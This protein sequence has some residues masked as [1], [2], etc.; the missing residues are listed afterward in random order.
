MT[1]WGCRRMIRPLF[2][3]REDR[4]PPRRGRSSVGRASRSQCEGQGFDSPRLHH[5]LPLWDLHGHLGNAKTFIPGIS[6]ASTKSSYALD[7]LEPGVAVMPDCFVIQPFDAGEFDKRFDDICKPALKRAG[8]DAY[9]VD[10]DPNADVL[11]DTI[12]ERISK[13]A[14]CLADITS[15]NPNVWYEL[16][17]AFAVERPVILI[18][19]ANR[20]D[21]FPFD[22]Q[23]RKVIRYRTESSSD[24]EKLGAQI[25]EK[26][27]A[28]LAKSLSIKKV[29]ETENVA[30]T[31]GL[32]HHEVLVLAILA[33]DAIIPESTTHINSLKHDAEKAGLTSV[34]F[35]LALRRLRKR[36]FAKTT[37]LESEEGY[38]FY[39]AVQ[40]T[41]FGWQWIEK[42]DDLF[43]LHKN[44]RLNSP[45][46]DDDIPF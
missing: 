6:P 31:E 5:F 34:G 16:G 36:N 9:R 45:S 13:A 32:H 8:L 23:H 33:G 19:S 42:H 2:G 40:L 29:A 44:E 21:K 10:R 39:M 4:R 1:G 14:M 11:I 24:F 22:I 12:E 25:T 26:A 17:F 43:I 20:N 15:D 35:G 27:D 28:I 37:E 18:C 46:L 38:G 7:G 30:P 3:R 41:E